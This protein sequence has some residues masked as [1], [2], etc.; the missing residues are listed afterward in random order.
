[1]SAV[2]AEVGPVTGWPMV[3]RHE[4][5]QSG[6][7][8]IAGKSCRG[9]LVCGAAGVGKT[10]LAMECLASAERAGAATVRVTATRTTGQLPLGAL[11]H[12]LPPEVTGATDPTVVYDA[13]SRALRE[14]AGSSQRLIAFVDDM[15]LLDATS[16][17]LLGRLLDAGLIFLIGTVRTG[18][19]VEDAVSMLWRSD[20]VLR[21]DLAD[22]PRRGIETLLHLAL[23]GPVEAATAQELWHASQGNVL[24]LRELVL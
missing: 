3:G 18:E 2:A 24:Y 4:E 5:L 11:A 22:L 23:G 21:V 10:R 12:L 8:A 16:T 7:R 6:L 15:H 1:M 19:P 20:A 9:W 13:V 17:V 14:R